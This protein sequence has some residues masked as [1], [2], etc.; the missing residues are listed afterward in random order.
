MRF[1]LSLDICRL[2]A[3]VVILQVNYAAG[4]PFNEDMV[5]GQIKTGQIARPGE[6]KGIALGSIAREFGQDRASVLGLQNP[7]KADA[8][9]LWSGRRIFN[10]QCSACHGYYSDSGERTASPVSK[11]VPTAPDLGAPEIA[12]KPDGHF[13]QYMHFGGVAVMPPYG[14][15]L[16]TT[17]H[18]DIV[19]FIR[20]VQ[21]SRKK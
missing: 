3:F 13:F 16:S 15:K 8:D 1:E 14:Y 19:N 5:D 4:F 12:A 6:E 9:S 21:Q 7:L 18:W 17:E 2:A 20:V 11:F 10:A